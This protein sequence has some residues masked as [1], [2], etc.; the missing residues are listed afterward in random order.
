MQ[1]DIWYVTIRLRTKY[2][3][4]NK[5]FLFIYNLFRLHFDL[6]FYLYD[7][8][9]I[10]IF[11]QP[12]LM[13]YKKRNPVN[14][15]LLCFVVWW[16]IK[17]SLQKKFSQSN[18][19]K[20]II[21]FLM[22]A[23][24]SRW[25]KTYVKCKQLS[26]PL[27]VQ[28]KQLKQEVMGRIIWQPLIITGCRPQQLKSSCGVTNS[29][30]VSAIIVSAKGGRR[31]VMLQNEASNVSFQHQ[32]VS[33]TNCSRCPTPWSRPYSKQVRAGAALWWVGGHDDAAGV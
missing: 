23:R 11:I 19:W 6:Y 26:P 27:T 8:D 9:F 22:Y 20:L 4:A 15:M 21:P 24:W 10:T 17:W 16:T 7:V 25:G 13:W 1:G 33:S 14:E 30:G 3:P 28:F 32:R 29:S 31:R 2:H 12:E 18:V 5:Y